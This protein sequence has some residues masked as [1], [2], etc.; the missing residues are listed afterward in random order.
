MEDISDDECIDIYKNNILE[1]FN[2]DCEH[3]D[4]SGYDFEGMPIDIIIYFENE[5]DDDGN[6][7]FFITCYVYD[8]QL[9][10]NGILLQRNITLFT[11]E[12]CS[13]NLDEI[14]INILKF[15]LYDFRTQFSYSKIIDEI[16]Y[17]ED[18]KDLEKKRM[19]RLKL[20]ENKTLESCCVCFEYNTVNTKCNHNVCRKCITNIIKKN[21]DNPSC[22]LCRQAI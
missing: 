4:L 6:Y 15:L 17:S 10:S 22:P 7:Y 16:I 19:A 2:N 1:S 12:F 9:L 20:I 13:S 21:S 8:N 18:K 3:Y 11:K 14:I 5:K